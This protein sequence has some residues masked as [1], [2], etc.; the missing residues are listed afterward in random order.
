MSSYK[1]RVGQE[2]NM[3]MVLIKRTCGHRDAYTGKTPKP[4]AHQKAGARPGT[5]LFLAPS[6]ASLGLLKLLRFGAIGNVSP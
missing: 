3:T 2:S 1:S 4:K 5:D 6:L